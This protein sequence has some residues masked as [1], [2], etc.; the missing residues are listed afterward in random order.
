MT[1]QISEAD[2][3]KLMHNPE[4]QNAMQS[5]GEEALK[6]PKVQQMLIEQAKKTMTP[7]NAALVAS[8]AK[9]WAND[10]AVQAKARYAAGMAME[11]A[12]AL[13]QKV[14]G[15]IEQGPAGLRFLAFLGGVY[16]CVL[17]VMY[18]I[19]FTH[20]FTQTV[21]YVQTI[22]KIIFALSTML[23][24]A[25]PAWIDKIPGL[26]GYQNLLIKWFAFMTTALGRGSF[27]VFQGINWLVLF[28]LHDILDG[29]C[30]VYLCLIGLMHIL[31]HFG[32]MPQNVAAKMKGGA[33]A[34][35][36]KLSGAG[37]SNA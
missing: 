35:Y 29:L 33:A 20:L 28:E 17:C 21:F 9:D 5:A 31:M 37:S 27:Y 14:I 1:G 30:G 13:G 25:D 3:A 24:E 11:G 2:M 23:F 22:F 12:G 26:S 4:V 32:I 18:M 8:K 10:P 36:S 7:E 16:S 19:A 34:G 15:C 6:D